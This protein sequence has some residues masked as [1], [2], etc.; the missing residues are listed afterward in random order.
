M[1]INDRG[2]PAPPTQGLSRLPSLTGMRWIAA[3]LV[4]IFHLGYVGGPTGAALHHVLGRAGH[5]GVTF[6][7]I[8]SG[9]VLTWSARPSDTAPKFWR[10]RLAKIFPNHWATF[11]LTAVLMAITGEAIVAGDA[12]PNLFLVHTWI[13]KL[14]S[15]ISMNAVSWSLA[16]ELVFYLTFPLWKRLFDRIPARRLWLTAGLIAAAIIAVPL[17]VQGFVADNPRI[18][19]DTFGPIS[20]DQLWLTYF[21]PLTRVLEFMLGIVLA[22]IVLTGRWIPINM[23]TAALLVVA[24]QA[25][26]LTIDS[27]SYLL[28]A[29]AG[30]ALPVALLIAAAASADARGA[31]SPFRSRTMVWLGE[32]S[33]AFYMVHKIVMTYLQ[34]VFTG[35]EENWGTPWPLS[36][37]LLFSVTAFAV[38]LV[39]AAGLYRFV[40]VPCLRRFGSSRKD[41][42]LRSAVS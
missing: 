41:K 12:V 3:F 33:F 9:F 37:W 22:R 4:F 5:L 19:Y 36:Q 16:C 24:G 15:W 27:A 25:V 21:F 28:S 39:A 14:E 40:E 32:I 30:P 17:L 31:Y 6:F 42:A 20:F 13:P 18:P 38:A 23:T 1:A 34:Q 26:A 8:L 7:F 11:L 29:S 35:G 10:R 2:Q